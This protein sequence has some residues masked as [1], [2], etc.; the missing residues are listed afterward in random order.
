MDC[1]SDENSNYDYSSEE[2]ELETDVEDD[3]E[4]E[5]ND[6]QQQDANPWMRTYPQENIVDPPHQFLPDAGPKNIPPITTTPI[7]FL[8]LFLTTTFIESI[9]LRT[10]QKAQYFILKHGHN[11]QPNSRILKW[12]TTTVSEVNAFI[13]IIVNMG[14][15]RKPTL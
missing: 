10:N 1:D 15:I 11:L 12:V 13:S 3:F 14:L 2:S 5:D 7:Q 9:V 6:E 4:S 8:Q